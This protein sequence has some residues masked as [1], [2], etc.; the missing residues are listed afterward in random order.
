MQAVF[1][2]NRRESC[3]R[4]CIA[5]CGG[6]NGDDQ[7]SLRDLLKAIQAIAENKFES[8]VTLCEVTRPTF[9]SSCLILFA[10]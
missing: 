2:T 8:S 9:S 3:I 6:I 7:P 1:T 5:A 10:F 4:N